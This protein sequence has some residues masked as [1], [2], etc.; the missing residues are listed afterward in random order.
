MTTG[1]PTMAP[2]M[3]QSYDMVAGL[4]DP[5]LVAS[6]LE[7]NFRLGPEAASDQSVV[8][9]NPDRR[10]ARQFIRLHEIVLAQKSPE[11]AGRAQGSPDQTAP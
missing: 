9:E 6:L 1:I 11:K 2:L 3:R 5:T 10:L 7:R 8:E 4:V